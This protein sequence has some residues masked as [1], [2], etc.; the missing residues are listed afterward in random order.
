MCFI[1]GCCRLCSSPHSRCIECHVRKPPNVACSTA[2]T[3]APAFGLPFSFWRSSHRLWTLEQKQQQFTFAKKQMEGNEF[4]FSWLDAYQL[5]TL[6]AIVFLASFIVRSI[7]T[8]RKRE[9]DTF[10]MTADRTLPTPTKLF[11]GPTP[12]QRLSRV[13]LSAM[14]LEQRLMRESFHVT[15]ET[16]FCCNGDFKSHTVVHKPSRYAYI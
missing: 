16:G 2:D 12:T 6:L 11:C 13:G 9:S 15:A 8:M 14:E 7:A 1:R 4:Q 3:L 10:P 5:G